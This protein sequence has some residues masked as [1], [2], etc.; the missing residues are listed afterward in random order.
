MGRAVNY[1][2]IYRAASGA[3]VRRSE[4]PVSKNPRCRP[5]ARAVSGLA[6]PF[7]GSDGHRCRR[8]SR[9]CASLLPLPALLDANNVPYEVEPSDQVIPTA[10]IG[11]MMWGSWPGTPA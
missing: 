4:H 11:P 8:R 7:S 5:T 1:L 10:D 3:G 2:E 6:R 9:A